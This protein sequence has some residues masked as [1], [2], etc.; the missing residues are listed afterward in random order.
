MNVKKTALA[1]AIALTMAGGSAWADTST[2]KGQFILDKT[3]VKGGETVNLALLGLTNSG[4]VDRFGE[5]Q[6]S[7][8]MAVVNTIKGKI[9]GGDINPSNPDKGYFAS[10]VKYVRLQQGVGRVSI[11]YPNDIVGSEETTDT[12][13]VYLQ[14]KTYTDKGG[15]EYNLIGQA[16]DKTITIKAGISAPA[17]LQFISFEPAP[18]ENKPNINRL[19][20]GLKARMTAGYEGGQLRVRGLAQSG[21]RAANIIK[22]EVIGNT[23]SAEGKPEKKVIYQDTQRMVQDEAIFTLTSEITKAGTYDMIASLEGTDV[24]SLT[25]VSH[26]TLTVLPTLKPAALKLS[27]DKVRITKPGA[28]ACKST[29]PHNQVCQGAKIT[30]KLLDEYG[31]DMEFGNPTTS[32]DVEKDLIVSFTDA[33]KVVNNNALKFRIPAYSSVGVPR[34]G[35]DEYLGNQAIEIIDKN[36][37]TSLVAKVESGGSGITNSNALVIKVAENSLTAETHEDF[38]GPQLAGSEFKAFYIKIANADGVPDTTTNPGTIDIKSGAN[39]TVPVERNPDTYIVEGFFQKATGSKKYLLSDQAGNYGQVWVMGEP[40]VPAAAH[41]VTLR[42]KIGE[43]IT[44]INTIFNKEHKQYVTSIAENA[45]RMVDAYGNAITENVGDFQVKSSAATITYVNTAGGS[46]GE[47]GRSPGGVVEVRYD[48]VG[49]KAFAGEDTITVTFNKPA[50][51][52]KS[53]M[54]KT[55]VPTAVAEGLD[56]I[57][58]YID[59]NDLPVNSEVALKVETLDQQ[60]NLF[61]HDN[62]VVTVTFNEE[63]GDDG[64]AEGEEGSEDGAAE[65]EEGSE[66]GAAEG[67]EGSEDVKEVVIVPTVYELIEYALTSGQCRNVGGT[68]ENEKCSD[69]N[70][71]RCI[72]NIGY[73]FTEAQGCLRQE[74]KTVASGGRLTFKTGSKLFVVEAGPRAGKFSLTFKDANK[75]DIKETRIFNVTNEIIV[76]PGKTEDECRKEGN[77]WM[78]EDKACKP[79]PDRSTGGAFVIGADGSQKSSNVRI[80]GGT[81]IEGGDIAGSG[82]AANLSDTPEIRFV[83][84]I[85]FDPD[86]EGKKVDIIAVALYQPNPFLTGIGGGVYFSLQEGGIAVYWNLTDVADIESFYDDKHTIVKDEPKVVEIFKGKF[87]NPPFVASTLDVWLGYRLDDGT[88]IFNPQSIQ[89]TLLP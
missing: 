61:M 72:N 5:S 50:L 47:P 48:T 4:E 54:V 27:A 76:A 26:D 25:M 69:T 19:S 73:I 11:Y 6:G 84:N 57:T 56:R 55:M 14:E 15:V 77:L 79:M 45:F 9:Q 71:D 66:D 60:G 62:L 20:G 10:D 36:K 7:T 86:H 52:S 32:T 49:S 34:D 8:I 42:N 78:D 22:L 85:K 70:A 89:V 68:Y 3:E 80:T 53:I 51:S 23:L 33:R 12:V 13:T 75:P 17:A 74:E 2:V 31:N 88:I 59:T 29:F 38:S 16:V 63:L 30:L 67:E 43:D 46:H 44:F 81:S 41:L 58:S 1:T 65:G 35:T 40:I 37:T 18:A 87:K 28:N 82:A 21:L 64:A 24:N 39:D 83:G